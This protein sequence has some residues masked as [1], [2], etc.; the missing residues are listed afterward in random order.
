MSR[1]RL[2]GRSSLRHLRQHPWQVALSVLGIAVG[3]AVVVAIEL[4]NQSA[5]RAFRVSTDQI[6]GRATHQ[7]VGGPAG[8]ADEVYVA[9][10]RDLG[11]RTAAPVIEEYA[12]VAAA[13]GRPA[14]LLHLVG[15]DPLAEAPFG[16]SLAGGGDQD[17]AR[18]LTEPGA[19]LL[20]TT[21][22]RRLG[23]T[24]GDELGIL[25]DGRAGRIHLI[26]LLEGRGPG[27][28]DLL[29]VD[30]ASAQE[31]LGCPGRL[32]R[33]DLVLPVGEEGRA[34]VDRISAA[35]PAGAQLLEAETRT[36][37][38]AAMTDSFRLNLRALSLLALLCGTFLVYN[39][40]SFSVLQRRQTLG[41][42]RALGV[43][44]RQILGQVLSEAAV[45]GLAGTAAG[46]VLG[47][48]L[49]HGLVKLVTQTINDLYFVVTVRQ[50][51]L[52]PS[53]L[54]AGML[55]GLGASL[56]AALAPARE[57]TMASPR[58]VLS[59]AALEHRSLQRLPALALTGALL[60]AGG[61]LLLWPARPLWLSFGG[62]FAV[63]LGC[64]LLTPPA[65]AWM[66]R[67]AA[68]L[69]RRRG[70]LLARMAARGVVASLSRTGVAMAAL[71]VAVSMTV[72]V[73]VMIDSFR[74]SVVRW[75]E[76]TLA[77]DVYVSPVRPG[78]GGTRAP[79]PAELAARVAALPGVDRV[80]TL[81]RVQIDTPRGPV[82][83][84][85]ADLDQRGR[86]SFHLVRGEAR[87]AWRAVSGKG[88]VLISEPFAF[89][90]G[91]ALGDS[92]ELP[93]DRGLHRFAIAGVYRDYGSDQGVVVLDRGTYDRLWRDEGFTALAVFAAPG[94][95]PETLLPRVRSLT[96]SDGDTQVRSNRAIREL[97]LEI[98]DR[99][100]LITG[101]L[102]LLAGA[103]AF[104]GVLG[105]LMALQLDR[106]RELAVLRANGLTPRQVWRLVTAQTAL[107]GLAA[108]LLSIPTGLLMAVIMTHVVN[109]RSFGWTVDLVLTPSVP[110]EALGLALA[111]ALLAG[112]YPAW[113]MARTSPALALREE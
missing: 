9:L 71:T 101:V 12:T 53:A 103:V 45:L 47:V 107:M 1:S 88:A 37:T 16:R 91:L 27:L 80:N 13:S 49:G 77:A 65:T 18:L 73:G 66:M 25:L 102:R 55:L 41:R 76:Y 36:A 106:A 113:R 51:A 57:A 44:R 21:S 50:L 46:L 61:G 97:S 62:M 24:P 87:A 59:R 98:F 75:L 39:T 111:A 38:T 67:G 96:G 20:A 17:P 100:F 81:R 104:L 8:L 84:A 10:R 52:P 70:G 22:A 5:E 40:V 43:T 72:G 85:A 26:G 83:L 93:T 69:A 30:V 112:I 86:D 108:G 64:A 68:E 19:A 31:L 35:L 58:D 15:I 33:I 109:R 99:T 56:G 63:I 74:A 4:A 7:V 6:T 54:A 89:H 29:V 28:E 60:L 92:L 79:L 32:S 82:R 48:V 42:L 95:D 78:H 2:L 23:L 3:V 110:L 94:V 34:L 14:E 90:H 11:I 105:G